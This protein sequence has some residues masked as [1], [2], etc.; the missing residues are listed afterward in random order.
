[1]RRVVF[2]ITAIAV[3]ASTVIGTAHDDQGKNM[4]ITIGNFSFLPQIV[5]VKAGTTV[6]WINKDD[7]P[8]TVSST[9]QK[10]RSGV[11]DTDGEFSYTFSDPGT[12]EY[13]CSVHP[14][15]TGK[16]IVQ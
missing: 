6:T 8:H 16:V 11:L 9:T 10:F 12:Y 5:T 7:V 13:F 14:H 2:C 1:M 4:R 15:M 3:A